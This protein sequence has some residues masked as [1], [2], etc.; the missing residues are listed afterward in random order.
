VLELPDHLLL[1]IEVVEM[2]PAVAQADPGGRVP[3]GEVLVQGVGEE[4]PNPEDQ[5]ADAKEQRSPN[6]SRHRQALSSGDA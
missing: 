2:G 6:R 1:A 4:D 5:L 3:K